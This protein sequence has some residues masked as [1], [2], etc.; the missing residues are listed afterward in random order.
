MDAFLAN[1]STAS[2]DLTTSVNAAGRATNEFEAAPCDPQ[3]RVG[4]LGDGVGG[5][6]G[7][8]NQVIGDDNFVT[9]VRNAFVKADAETLPNSTID[10]ALAHAGISQ[11][12]QAPVTVNDPVYN[13]ATMMSGWSDDPVCT[14]T[15]HFFEVEEDLVMPDP[16]RVLGWARSYS[17][18]FVVDGPGG[19][20]WSSWATTRLELVD[21]GIVRFW[22]PDGRQATVVI[23]VDDQPV[24]VAG[25]EGTFTRNTEPG[26][27]DPEEA[28][29]YELRWR[30]SSS[31]PGM[32]WHF[33]ADG[34]LVGIDDPFGGATTCTRGHGGRLEAMT[35]E[36]GRSLWLVWDGGRIA[37]LEASDGR[38]VL[39]H[40]EGADL[41]R[42]ERA[43][44][45][46]RYRSDDAGRVIELVDADGVRLMANTY[47]DEGRVT[48]QTAPTGRVSTYR[49]LAPYTATVTDE[50]GGPATVF[51][52]DA[53]GR[54]VELRI[55]DGRRETRTFDEAGNPVHVVG[56]DGGEIARTFDV[57]G[58]CTS[59]RDA[60]GAVNRWAYD[61]AGRVTRHRGPG[62]GVWKLSYDG[63]DAWPALV[64]G[65][66]EDVRRFTSRNGLPLSAVDADGVSYRAE[67]DADGSIAAVVDGEG[68][69]S[70]FG[71]H[72]SG[73]YEWTEAPTG[74]RTVFD[75]DD[76]GR[77]LGGVTPGGERVDLAWSAAGRLR[78]QTVPGRGMT[79]FVWDPAGQVE[80]LTDPTS[81]T[82]R[83]AHDELGDVT[84]V[85]LPG[86]GRWALDWD[87][88]GG[89]E[90]LTDPAGE[91]WDL[92]IEQGGEWLRDPT[93]AIHRIET[94]RAGGVT[95]AISPGGAR[96]ETTVDAGKRHQT[97]RSSDGTV[98]EIDRDE[99]GRI[100]RVS[101]GSITATRSYTAGG[102]LAAIESTDGNRWSWTY[103]RAGR[104][105]RVSGARGATT[106]E[107]DAA[108]RVVAVTAPTGDRRALVYGDDGRP[109]EVHEDGHITRL[110]W[111]PGGRLRQVVQ[112][113]G[114]VEA[115]SWDPAGR[116]VSTT[117]PLGATT[118]IER[119]TDGQVVAVQAADGGRWSYQRDPMGR[120]V[121]VVD[122]LGRT[123]SMSWDGVG[124]IDAVESGAIDHRYQWSVD[125]ELISIRSGPDG[126]ALLDLDH[127]LDARVL[128]ATDGRE[129]SE[130]GWDAQGRTVRSGPVDRPTRVGWDDKTNSISLTPG[131]SQMCR[132]HRDPDGLIGSIELPSAREVTISRDGG[133]RVV[134]L[135]GAG[136]TRIW[137]RDTAGRP[138]VYTEKRDATVSV[139][140]L[141]WDERGRLVREDRDGRATTYRY[142]LAGQLTGMGTPGGTWS[143]AYDAC[144][145]LSRESGP[146]GTRRFSYD[147]AGQLT[148]MSGD[149]DRGR[150]Y[151]YDDSGRRVGEV[152]DDGS[153]TSYRWDRLG[154]LRSVERT[155]PEG[156]SHITSLD[157]GPLGELNDVDGVSVDWWPTGMF[158]QT[159]AAI[160]DR[161]L[162]CVDGHPVAW[163]GPGGEVEWV[164]ADWSGSVGDTSTPWGPNLDGAIPAGP[165]LGWGGEIEAG[166]LIWLR[167]RVYDPATRAFLSRDSVNG[168]LT[169]PG[170]LTNPY[171][172]AGNDPVNHRDPSGQR[173]VTAAQADKQIASWT[174]PQWGKIASVAEAVGGVV[175]C[176]TPL[177]PIG[178]GILIGEASSVG[179]QLLLNHGQVNWDNV[180]ISGAAGGVAGGVGAI[181]GGSSI[182]A[183]L[184]ANVGRFSPMLASATPGI[185]SGAAGGFSGSLTQ[186]ALSGGPM[187]PA[188]L[189]TDT[190]IGAATGGILHGRTPDVAP[191]Q[192]PAWVNLAGPARTAHILYGDATGGGHLYP[193]LPGKTPFPEG[194][195]PDKVM[196][197]ISDVATSPSSTW[198]PQGPKQVISGGYEGVDIRVIYK[199][200]TDE[201]ITGHPT[202]LPNKP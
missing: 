137:Q 104:V 14:A 174:T 73:V 167:N 153:R 113:D 5:A 6:A 168:E 191:V 177:A 64:E 110:E 43:D 25:V 76:A 88:S 170:A 37:G 89:I 59:E 100:V 30:W 149:D 92:G 121:T 31:W 81:A 9:T 158:G 65:P 192:E 185:V 126:S 155:D 152:A 151:S 20:G 106:F 86:G 12:A 202:N 123:T 144:G 183:N 2:S 8:T 159:P 78:S 142:D 66:G 72:R 161:Q 68:G 145:R 194:W 109:A 27:Q 82:T 29:R 85:M 46:R 197:S 49:Y 96:T 62:G 33:D 129:A 130:L 40:Y 77:T 171:Q 133:G 128:R 15:G 196:H 42:V 193:G 11:S 41:V 172:Y 36:G 10:A 87:Q 83:L 165:R 156:H 74:E 94:D 160:G 50:T 124:R 4:G 115:G 108:G 16:L 45:G 70:T 71:V 195:S 127:D 136:L 138:V 79:S 163:A 189:A 21:P 61:R 180:A 135:T 52:H 120:P 164:A 157:V 95:A 154:R 97:N 201:I 178:A 140:S 188:G 19:R 139:T 98:T 47:D 181:V 32:T 146:E 44:G 117:D 198:V 58:N 143:W 176:F 39:Y 1:V 173:P 101:D 23:A 150:D 112:P 107:R 105:H 60:D 18:R 184:A 114:A 48:S 132:Y 56:L 118:R 35:H 13:G 24:A 54:L 99:T 141:A 69:R 166:G 175:L 26:P 3:F 179:S 84:E 53:I 28:G 22:G 116:L 186:T 90:G 187:N 162:V 63:D 75:V 125:G 122:P 102:R 55:G 80:A 199:P 57:D 134:E 38:S 119:D 67:R 111:D 147:A 34:R 131:A 17:S 200:G 103:D 182:V 91:R 7:W 190:V 169:R 93:G 148:R 51:R